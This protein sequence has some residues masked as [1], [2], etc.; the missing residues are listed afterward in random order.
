MREEFVFLEYTYLDKILSIHNIKL[1][2]TYI[3]LYK[4]LLRIIKIYI[5]FKMFINVF[6]LQLILKNGSIEISVV[7]INITI[8]KNI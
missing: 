5:L 7:I 1:H 8:Y 4:Y 2:C 3:F 6:C